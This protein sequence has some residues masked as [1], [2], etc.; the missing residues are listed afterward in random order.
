MGEKLKAKR[1]AVGLKVKTVAEQLGKSRITIWEYET[2]RRKP[3]IKILIQLA[4]LYGCTINDF[5]E[6]S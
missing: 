3:S 1:K 2:N 6:N 4:K 5:V